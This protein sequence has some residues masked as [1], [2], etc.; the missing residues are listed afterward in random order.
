M[1]VMR[2]GRATL[3]SNGS[4]NSLSNFLQVLSLMVAQLKYLE[5]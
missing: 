5:I 1:G 2:K 4:C 3:P